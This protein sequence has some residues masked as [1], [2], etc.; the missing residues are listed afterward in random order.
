MDPER[1]RLFQE[2]GFDLDALLFRAASQH[3]LDALGSA[4]NGTPSLGGAA[5][6]PAAAGGGSG[7]GKATAG[8]ATAGG[9]KPPV[10]GTQVRTPC[11]LLAS[12]MCAPLLHG[13]GALAACTQA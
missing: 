8:A 6:A 9:G 5:A 12:E 11:W 1:R 3:G 7:G 13:R 2:D 4:P 10:L